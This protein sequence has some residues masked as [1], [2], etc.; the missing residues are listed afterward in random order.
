MIIA[1]TG[2]SGVGKTMVV[3]NLATNLPENLKVFHFDDIGMPDWS[4]V[5]AEKWQEETTHLW[6]DRL[7]KIS[8]EENVN[9]LFEGST[10]IQFYL[11]AL[12]L[13]HI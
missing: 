7:V 13:I 11:D 1:I 2:A 8:Q 3:K 4:K 12:S 10:R 6:I 9:I 5:D